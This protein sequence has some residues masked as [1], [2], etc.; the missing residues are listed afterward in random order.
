MFALH[1]LYTAFQPA[2]AHQ[3]NCLHLWGPRLWAAWHCYF[4]SSSRGTL[5]A[6][7]QG[8]HH[9]RFLY[10]SPCPALGQAWSILHHYWVNEQM[11]DSFMVICPYHAAKF[12]LKLSA[13]NIKKQTALLHHCLSQ[14]FV[15]RYLCQLPHFS[16]KETLENQRL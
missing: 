15:Q 10:S 8:H 3:T 7:G 2:L 6:R 1:P 16:E 12:I 5:W 13:S 14:P 9:G 4:P 11:K